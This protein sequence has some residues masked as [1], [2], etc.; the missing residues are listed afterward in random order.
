[1]LV[2]GAPARR[3]Q[4][5][6]LES[7]ELCPAVISSECIFWLACCALPPPRCG[8][9][10]GELTW[11]SNCSKA[12]PCGGGLRNPLLMAG[13]LWHGELG[14]GL[15][16]PLLPQTCGDVWGKRHSDESDTATRAGVAV[17][18]AARVHVRA[19][20]ACIAGIRGRLEPGGRGWLER[21]AVDAA[22]TAVSADRRRY[23]GARNARSYAAARPARGGRSP[24]RPA[25]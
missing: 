7:G 24:A 19:N 6:R 23:R 12:A 15:W 8:R 20:T 25:C 10:L 5:R 22:H 13:F 3:M 14:A 2:G 9:C 1:M 16:S 11:S 21:R 4:R 17:L 18:T